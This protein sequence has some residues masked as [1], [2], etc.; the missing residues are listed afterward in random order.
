MTDDSS[1]WEER[2]ATALAGAH[3][4]MWQYKG[5]AAT[6][7]AGHRGILDLDLE[8]P[9]RYLSGPAPVCYVWKIDVD[10]GTRDHA[11]A[12]VQGNCFHLLWDEGDDTRAAQPPEHLTGPCARDACEACRAAALV[13]Q[14]RM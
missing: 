10:D 6:Y 2:A 9:E 13:A 14:L 8:F 12:D 5:R 4:P 3:L 11:Y 1:G 7:A